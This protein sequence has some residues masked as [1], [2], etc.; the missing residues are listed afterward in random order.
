MESQGCQG[1][2]LGNIYDV[3][4]QLITGSVEIID[5]DGQKNILFEREYEIVEE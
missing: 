2:I 5:S 1:I 3:V 4:D